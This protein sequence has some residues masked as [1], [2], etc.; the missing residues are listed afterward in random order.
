[1][2]DKE[3]FDQCKKNNAKA[4]RKL[5]DARAGEF[6]DQRARLSVRQPAGSLALDA[7]PASPAHAND[8]TR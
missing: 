4:Q 5:Y 8:P 2:I 7:A 6:V 3:L 1:M